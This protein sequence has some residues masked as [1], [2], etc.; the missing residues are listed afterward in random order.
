MQHAGCQRVQIQLDIG[1]L[2][3]SRSVYPTVQLSKPMPT[4]FC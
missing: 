1:Q 4:T 2:G 3:H